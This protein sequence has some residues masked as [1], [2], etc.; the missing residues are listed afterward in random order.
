MQLSVGMV[1]LHNVVA[2]EVKVT[3]PVAPPGR[4]EADSDTVSPYEVELGAADAFK[5]VG[6]FVIVKLVP[7][8]EPL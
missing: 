5:D 8:E 2:P 6:S 4:L 7:T 3:V 1:A